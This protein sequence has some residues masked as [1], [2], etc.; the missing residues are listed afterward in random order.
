MP[1]VTG[2]HAPAV[3]RSEPA[4][5]RVAAGEE[6]AFAGLVATHHR[7]GKFA[8]TNPTK[9]HGV[10]NK[11]A[12]VPVHLPHARGALMGLNGPSGPDLSPHASEHPKM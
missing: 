4:F 2:R 11:T 7:S 12:D 1:A 8:T 9:T 6:K 5:R 3:P 10:S